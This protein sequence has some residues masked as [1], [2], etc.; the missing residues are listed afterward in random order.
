MRGRA[1]PP[2]RRRVRGDERLKDAV[3]GLAVAE[4]AVGGALRHMERGG[5][6][7]ELVPRQAQTA[8][9]G[10]QGVA[11]LAVERRHT[12]LLTDAVDDRQ[13]EVQQVLPDERCLADK[14]QKS[15][16]CLADGR[17]SREHLVRN[18]GQLR[19]DGRHGRGRLHEQGKPLGRRAV[20]NAQRTEFDDFGRSPVQTGGFD[21]DD[22]VD[23]TG[24]AQ[25]GAAC[26]CRALHIRQTVG[27]DGVQGVS[28]FDDG[29][30]AAL[31]ADERTGNDIAVHVA[32]DERLRVDIAFRRQA[33][34]LGKRKL[35]LRTVCP[36]P[37]EVWC[38]EH[39]VTSPFR[40]RKQVCVRFG[41]KFSHLPL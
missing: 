33:E 4:G 24:R 27:V 11:A 22:R 7:F 41:A 30:A 31:P 5:E 18:A 15:G 21:V 20:L 35:L 39:G 29:V 28:D 3:R 2:D 37:R 26:A 23:R 9:R 38:D 19:T 10:Q 1:A 14:R 6:G 34:L 16:K 40:N 17:L 36:M 8:A 32:V 25:L 12:L 13:V